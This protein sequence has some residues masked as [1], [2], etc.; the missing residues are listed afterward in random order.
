MG[1]TLSKVGEQMGEYT[2][3]R[4][5]DESERR[6]LLVQAQQA[7]MAG[8]RED[9]TTTRAL[10]AQESTERRTL[11]TA[12]LQE[13]IRSGQPQSNAGRMARD[14]GLTP[15]TQAFQDFVARHAELDV[16]RAQQ[17]IQAQNENLSLRREAADR[18]SATEIK[19]ADE[20]SQNISS[21]RDNALL[22]REAMRL[23]PN[24][25]PSNLTEGVIT[26]LRRRL[27]STDPVVVNTADIRNI[28]NRLTLGSLKE[29]FPG[30]ISNDERI[31]LAAVS[32]V[33]A[34]SREERA[35]IM[36]RASD[37]LERVI[38]RDQEHLRKIRSGAFGRVD[39][40]QG[41][42]Q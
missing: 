13:Y 7:R 41:G 27:G 21:A 10:A 28:L 22:L 9:L 14:A 32:G 4:R 5:A 18:L 36:Q 1:E 34:A 37:A 11:N 20:T 30:S 42:T 40:T 24:A 12:L 16:Q 35:R 17:L 19:L 15:G 29:T 2:K 6:N 3:G 23:N 39:R 38:E 25:S 31:A 26:D 8:A 33:T